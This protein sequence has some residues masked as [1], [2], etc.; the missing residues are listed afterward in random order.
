MGDDDDSLIE[1][2]WRRQIVPDDGSSVAMGWNLE[3]Y[4]D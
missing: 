1:T 4:W 2:L 3:Y